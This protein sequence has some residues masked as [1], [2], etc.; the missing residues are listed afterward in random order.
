ME[1]D[2]T[3]SFEQ[4]DVIY[5]NTRIGEWIRLWKVLATSTLITW[6]AFYCFEIYVADGVPSLS[7]MS[8]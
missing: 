5:E 3:L 1:P 2:P 8:D 7:W 4:G 6:P